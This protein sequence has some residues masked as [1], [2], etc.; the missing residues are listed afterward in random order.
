[1]LTLLGA[2][3]FINRRRLYQ[4]SV[5]NAGNRETIEAAM[6]I[7]SEAM[8]NDPMMTQNLSDLLTEE[9][10]AELSAMVSEGHGRVDNQNHRANCAK[11]NT[12]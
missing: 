12:R 4:F 10:L 5:L 1:M 9:N 2:S 7:L 8:M 3:H 11:S 6:K